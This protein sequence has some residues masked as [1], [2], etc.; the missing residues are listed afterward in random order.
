MFSY[1]QMDNQGRQLQATTDEQLVMI[2][3]PGLAAG[4]VVRA[5]EPHDLD[6]LPLQV[7]DIVSITDMDVPPDANSVPWW[8]GK[9]AFQVGRFPASHVRVI[10]TAS[11][12]D[13]VVP[14]TGAASGAGG[15]G[16]GSSSGL[17]HKQSV[18]QT[19]STSSAPS[20]PSAS[21]SGSALPSSAAGVPNAAS[22]S[23]AGSAPPTSQDPS[24]GS[25]LISLFTVELY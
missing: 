12:P 3:T 18:G 20:N 15:S 1:D 23:S 5:F 16:S 10:G 6:Q 24:S 9:K 2:N 19:V 22:A 13:V 21:A 7:G 17:L 14:G 25:L 8:K 11:V 4:Y